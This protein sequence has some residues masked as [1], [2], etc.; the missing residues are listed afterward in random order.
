[1]MFKTIHKRGVANSTFTLDFCLL[2]GVM[3]L[4]S[5]FNT[6]TPPTIIFND[7]VLRSCW[8]NYNSLSWSNFKAFNYEV[9]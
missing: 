5:D 2:V 8:L 6:L 1:M 7:L 3:Y 4:H 9:I